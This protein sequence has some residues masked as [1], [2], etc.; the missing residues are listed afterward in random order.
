MHKVERSFIL[1]HEEED[2]EEEEEE[3]FCIRLVLQL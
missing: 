3:Y 2:E 1:I